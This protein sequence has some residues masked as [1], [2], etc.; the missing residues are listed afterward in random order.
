MDVSEAFL[1]RMVTA[2]RESAAAQQASA[3]ALGEVVRSI[4][5]MSAEMR[6][7]ARDETAHYTRLGNDRDAA[8]EELKLH[9]SK[10]LIA[11]E[12]WWRW[13]VALSVAAMIL[14]NLF[15]IPIAEVFGVLRGLKP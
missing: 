6:E 9:I 13:F 4:T 8:V 5:L 10:E 2:I 1:E 15:S 3:A 14:S 12:F 11:R 7:Q